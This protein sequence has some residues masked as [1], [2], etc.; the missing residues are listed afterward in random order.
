MWFYN[1]TLEGVAFE[2]VV[3]TNGSF[4]DSTWSDISFTNA[5]FNNTT[6]YNV[7]VV[8]ISSFSGARFIDPTVNGHS[9]K[10]LFSSNTISDYFAQNSE[11]CNLHKMDIS[12]PSSCYVADDV[13]YFNEYLHDLIISTGALPGNIMSA[14]VMY[15]FI[16]SFWLCK[17]RCIEAWVPQ[18]CCFEF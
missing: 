12:L 4:V 7:T 15:F 5:T 6:F 1:V 16:R 14:V 18:T 8:N 9:L 10:G 3:I 17:L 13:D 2:N 11:K